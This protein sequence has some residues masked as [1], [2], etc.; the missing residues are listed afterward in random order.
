[1]DKLKM[2][3]PNLVEQN[4]DKLAALFPNCVTESKDENGKLKQAIDFD[5]LKQELSR[6]IVDGPQERYQLNWPGK[7]E[8]LL[9]ANAPIAKT[10][11]PCREESVNFDTTRNLF[12]EGDNLDALKLLQETYLGKVKMIYIDPPYNTG[13]DFIY[14]DDFA[15]DINTYTSRSNQIDEQANRLVSNTESNG[16]FHSDWLSMMY[17]RLKLAKNFLREDGVIFISIDDDEQSNLKKIADE[18]FGENNFVANLVWDK[19]RKNDARYFSVGHEY[20]L[21]YF[22][23]STFVKDEGIVYRGMKDGVE[24]VRE[25]FNELRTKY[26]DNWDKVRDGMLEFY[27]TISPED[28]RFPLIRFRK[29]DAAGPYRDDGN[30]NWPGGGGP[31]Y[32]I[33]HPVT[34]KPCK[35]PASGWRYPNPKRFWEEVDAGKVVFGPDETTVPRI[36][37][38][39]FEN[40]SQVMVSV[41]YSYA[42]TA[43]NEFN[44][45]FDGQRVFDNP[46]P[47]KDIKQLINYVTEKDDLI[48]DFFAGSATTAHAVMALNAE[49]FG[50][51]K[52]ILVQLPEIC[53]EKTPAFNLG[54]KSIA[55]I[56][57]DRIRKVGAQ[58]I[59]LKSENKNEIAQDIGFRVLKIDTSNM[60]DIYYS[61]DAVTQ[62]DLFDQ[63]ENVKS[64]RTEEDLLFQVM[65]DWGVDLTLPIRRETIADKAV[66]FVDAQSDNSH[67]AL[68]ACFDK[69]GSIDE[70]FIKQLAAFSPLRLVFRD[71][72]FAS[73]AAKT[74][75]EQLLKQLSATTD[76]KT[77]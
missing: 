13:K 21:V 24:E 53:K 6:H 50:A 57:K 69:T 18:I 49:G 28:P 65:L 11:R 45:I 42:Q 15:E 1:M 75:A 76:V 25:K 62:D 59:E 43:T 68:V 39:L 60:S 29:F 47:V 3:S 17:S 37:T 35:E 10:L 26:Q 9:T 54:Y 52:Y 20:M 44:N 46:K 5:L 23:N 33:L 32:E 22:K 38:N 64:D 63:V 19:N 27:S 77:I 14:N 74:N 30:I 12:I 48:L 16:R 71:A 31:R 4:I 7:R 36:R 72:G 66:F 40:N 73:D 56:A 8:A 41:N 2:H 67:G 70:D 51:R 55:D 58:F 61:P 34:G